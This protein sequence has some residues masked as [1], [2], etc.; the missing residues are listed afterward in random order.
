MSIGAIIA[1]AV[2]ASPPF[3]MWLWERRQG[4][5]NNRVSSR[6]RRRARIALDTD[7]QDMA[8]KDPIYDQ[9]GRDAL[10]YDRYGY[11]ATLRD[12]SGYDITGRDTLGHSWLE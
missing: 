9:F 8:N 1:V 6:S 12:R 4:S 5:R 10:G 2:A 7:S 3:L 11:D